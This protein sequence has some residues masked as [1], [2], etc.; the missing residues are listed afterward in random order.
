MILITLGTQDKT[1]ERLLK[2]VDHEIEKKTINDKVIVQAGSTKY[3]SK[4]MEILDLIPQEEFDE[5]ISKCDLLITHGGVGSI[6]AGV[7]RGKKVIA[8]PRLAKYKEHVNDHQIQIVEKFS[9]DKYIMGL[10]D[11]NGLGKMIEKAK[12]FKPRKFISNTS[13]LINHIEDYI[14][15]I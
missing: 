15:N 2:A 14:D 1:F 8:V 10:K 7:T 6:L 13:N 12:S 11:L 9:K 3:E 4:N 5:L